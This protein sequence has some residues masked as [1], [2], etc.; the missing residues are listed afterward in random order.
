M[1][2]VTLRSDLTTVIEGYGQGLIAGDVDAAMSHISYSYYDSNNVDYWGRKTQVMIALAAGD[3]LEYTVDVD[4]SRSAGDHASAIGSLTT[5]YRIANT[6]TV[7]T[8]TEAK[9]WEF[10]RENGRWRIVSERLR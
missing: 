3:Y 4:A 8:K 9:E 7:V 1:G 6:A 5:M 10:R 2:S